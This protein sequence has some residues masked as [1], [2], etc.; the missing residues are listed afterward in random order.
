MYVQKYV[1]T[2]F[3][4]DYDENMLANLGLQPSKVDRMLKDQIVTLIPDV[5]RITK[6]L[7]AKINEIFTKIG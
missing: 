2:T 7:I 6:D 1:P 4:I 3:V 5:V